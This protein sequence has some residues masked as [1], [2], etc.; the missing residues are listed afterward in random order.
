MQFGPSFL[1]L[2]TRG[3]TAS[4]ASRSAGNGP[5]NSAALNQPSKSSRVRMTGILGWIGFTAS[6]AALD[7]YAAHVTAACPT[8][9]AETM[10]AEL[11]AKGF[12]DVE[13]SFAV[14]GS[15][16]EAVAGPE[17]TATVAAAC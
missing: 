2:F 16:V 8:L 6:F 17:P 9:K 3:P 5:G 7:E 1:G 11:G 10:F 12:A 15:R 13:E 4:A 14:L